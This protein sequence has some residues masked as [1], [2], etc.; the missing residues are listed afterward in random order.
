MA[1]VDRDSTGITNLNASP[2][3]RNDSNA[4]GTGIIREAIGYVANAADDSAT[5]VHRFCRIPSNARVSQVL[6]HT[7]LA[8]T[9]GNVDIGLYDTD[10]D[11]VG[12]VVD[13]DLFASA[14]AITTPSA[15]NLDVTF[16]SA[17]YTVAETVKPLW[18]VLGLTADP[19]KDYDV[20]TTI[21]TNYNG[22]S[23][24]QT[25]KVRYTI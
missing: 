16:E 5:S 14:L 12:A 23:V 15:L 8:A 13:A 19:Q 11:G 4:E 18:E 20:A 10:E 1:I 3:V 9:A 21:T 25:I 6:F 2:L 7:L 17:E 22:A 24:G